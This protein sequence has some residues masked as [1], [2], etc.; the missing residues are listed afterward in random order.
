MNPAPIE[1]IAAIL[2]GVALI[3]TFSTKIFEQLARAQPA[4][5][6]I[7]HFLGEVEVVFGF[8]AMVLIAMMLMVEG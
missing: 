6:G 4:H 5:A 2:F 3:H 1:L 8:W 7:W